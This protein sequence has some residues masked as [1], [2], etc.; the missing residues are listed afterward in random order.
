MVLQLAY[1]AENS[2][3]FIQVSQALPYKYKLSGTIHQGEHRAPN[4]L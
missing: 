2:L 1:C 4:R 3:L